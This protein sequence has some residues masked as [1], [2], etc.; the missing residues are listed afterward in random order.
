MQ[1][2]VNNNK[3]WSLVIYN[4]CI[5]GLVGLFSQKYQ[6]CITVRVASFFFWKLWN[7]INVSCFQRELPTDPLQ[8]TSQFFHWL[9]FWSLLQKTDIGAGSKQATTR[10][11]VVADNLMVWHGAGW[12]LQEHWK[13]GD[14]VFG[15]TVGFIYGYRQ[16]FLWMIPRSC[17]VLV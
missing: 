1:R 9:D 10:L 16:G 11:R 2:W 15:F 3:G 6:E 7:I 5:L 14:H 8:Y 13:W 4:W 17:R 12:Q